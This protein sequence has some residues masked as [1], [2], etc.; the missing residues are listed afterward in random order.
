MPLVHWHE[1]RFAKTQQ[2]NFGKIIYPSLE[3]IIF[4]S[5]IPTEKNI[6]YKC[7]VIYDSVSIQVEFSPYQKK[8]INKLVVRVDDTINYHF[9]YANRERLNILSQNLKKAEEMLVVKNNL[10]TDTSF[11]NIALFDSKKWYTPAYPLL[12]GTRRNDLL[13]KNIIHE[14]DIAIDHLKDYLKIKLFN[15]MIDWNEAWELDIKNVF[16]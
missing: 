8:T 6:R 11:T 9:K 5:N 10:L 16:I 15:A 12:Q 7:R 2:A 1:Q 14:K 13:S 3:E 4:R